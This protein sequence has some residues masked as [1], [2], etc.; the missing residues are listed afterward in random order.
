M[1]FARMDELIGPA[2][3]LVN[4]AGV[5]GNKPTLELSNEDWKRNISIN[6]DGVFYCCREAGSRMKDAGGG[7]IVNI[8]S[9]Y[10]LVAPPNRLHYC[11]PKAAVEMMTRALAVEW[12]QYGIRVNGVAPGYVRT[13]LLEQLVEQGRVDLAAI[14]KRTPLGRLGTVDEIA[15]AV[16]YLCDPRSSYITGHMLPVDG[17]WTS[18]GYT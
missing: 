4:N 11:A 10:A 7:A 14:E 13:Q 18:Y 9:I 17:G 3:I 5:G 1:G 15:D 6:L 2:S 16:L 8:G 12:A